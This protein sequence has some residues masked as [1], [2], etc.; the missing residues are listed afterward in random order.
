MAQ[1]FLDICLSDIPKER[2][3]TA[4]NGKKYL[5]LNVGERRTPDDRGNDHYVSI[6]IP[7][8]ERKDGDKTIYIGNG[9]L[10]EN[11]PQREEPK[12]AVNVD[13]DLPF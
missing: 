8:D 2:I 1:L 7:K 5:K 10:R 6:Y 13:T 3:K 11:S 9:K 4:S 12:P